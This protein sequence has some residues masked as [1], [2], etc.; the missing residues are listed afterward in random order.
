MARSI[1]QQMAPLKR[2]CLAQTPRGG[3][4]PRHGGAT[5]GSTRAWSGGR[6]AELL[7]QGIY[8]GSCGKQGMRQGKQVSDWLV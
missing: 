3:G 1:D 5:R 8:F 4:V 6:G 2:V 7:R